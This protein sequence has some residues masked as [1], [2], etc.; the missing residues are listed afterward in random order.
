MHKRQDHRH[1]GHREND[2]V[3]GNLSERPTG[4]R[5]TRIFPT[6]SPFVLNSKAALSIGSQ[7]TSLEVRED[8]DIP[9]GYTYFGQFV[10]HD[11][12][13]DQSPDARVSDLE[14]VQA[15]SPSL[16]LDSLYGNS[17]E[18]SEQLLEDDGIR[19]RLGV[20]STEDSVGIGHVD[21]PLPFDIPRKF[22]DWH[23]TPLIPDTRNDE[24]LAVSQMH[25]LWMRFHNVVADHLSREQGVDDAQLFASTRMLVTQHYQFIVLHDFVKRI[26]HP[27]IYSSVVGN[28]KSRYFTATCAEVPA[29]PLEFSVAAFRFGHSLV[30][31]K[32]N[33]NLN[34][35]VGGRFPPAEFSAAITD[36]PNLSLFTFTSR[37]FLQS[38][39]LPS[40]W[41]INWRNFFDFNEAG[42]LV[43]SIPQKAKAIDPFLS[44]GM[45]RIPNDIRNLAVANLR[46]SGL[47]GIPSGQDVARAME[48]RP[49]TSKEMTENIGD[50]FARLVNEC[51]FGVKAPLWFYILQEAN[52]LHKGQHLGEVGS[53]IV[54]ETFVA[55][56]RASRIS[57][58]RSNWDINGSPLSINGFSINTLSRLI[59]W[60]DEREPIINPLRDK[61][62]N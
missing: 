18:Q 21:K 61:R 8:S 1:G 37:A 36:K 43:G 51:E 47:R 12:T 56:I 15:R 26:I 38:R 59:A 48:V 42:T 55:L 50:E 60:I 14:L 5:F 4:F 57:I 53:R 40:S 23:A 54:A 41:I 44:I 28:G 11:I 35:S 10:D 58:L 17:P 2:F 27:D 46:R 62:L 19:F 33:W 20:T 13:M 24:N 49:L 22:D 34:F 6:L 29:M 31:Q 7:M 52:A 25:L 45:G 9:A 39:A 3:Q 32:Y 30:R 16:D